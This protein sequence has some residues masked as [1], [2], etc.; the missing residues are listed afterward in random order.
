MFRGARFKKHATFVNRHFL[1]RTDF[2]ETTFEIAP[3]FQNC[4]LHQDTTFS[5]ADFPDR[6]GADYVDA[7]S[8]Y[9]TLKLAMEN[10]RA[11]D[12]EARFYAYEQQSLRLKRDTAF[13]VKFLSWLYEK[14]ADYGRAFM[15]PVYCLFG[16]LLIFS[17]IYLAAR[18]DVLITWA[19]T[20]GDVEDVVRFALQQ[21]FHPFGL[22]RRQALSSGT[23]VEAVPLWLAIVAALHSVLTLS[24]FAL[25]LLAIR[26]RFRLS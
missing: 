2:R 3:Q 14:T 6:Q 7:A 12:D 16:T 21:V 24:L 1:H 9:R 4:I 20:W 19:V 15:R 17:L 11:R 18:S 10:V 23:E 8:A 22:L 25:F 5:D 13:S 26:R